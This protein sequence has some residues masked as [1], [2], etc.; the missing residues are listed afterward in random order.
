MTEEQLVSLVRMIR[1]SSGCIV[2]LDALISR[3]E[4]NVIRPQCS[5]YIFNSDT[6]PLLS[7]EEVVQ[8]AGPK[9]GQGT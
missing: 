1:Q 7:P 2:D 5:E 8:K 4:N 6:G 9:R 3:F